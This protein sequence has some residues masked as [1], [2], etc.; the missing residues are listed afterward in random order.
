VKNIVALTGAGISKASGIPTFVEMGD[1]RE[2]LS[3]DYFRSYP[4][5]F[6]DIL[7]NMKNT[8]DKAKP[9]DGHIALAEYE[10][11][12]VTMNIDGLHKKAGSEWVIEIHG[13]F[14]VVKCPNCGKTY[15]FDVVKESIYCQK[16]K[17]I[18]EPNVVLYGDMIPKYMEAAKLIASADRLLVVGTSFY[19]ST[20]GQLCNIARLNGIKIDII[21]ERA[22][23]EVR[24]YLKEYFNN[25]KYF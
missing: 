18:L 16:C 3:R 21:N 13:N 23:V 19:T 10:V 11:P 20:A 25:E 24:K 2:K 8:I 9:N 15:E 4:Q 22:E 7:I 12:I 1:I 14:E 5:D 6:Y 17:G